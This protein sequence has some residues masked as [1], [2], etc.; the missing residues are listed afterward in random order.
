MKFVSFKNKENQERF[1]LLYKDTIV[2]LS[3]QSSHLENR[4]PSNILDFLNGGDEY[5][6]IVKGLVR[7]WDAKGGVNNAKT[8]G[9][10]LLSPIPHPPSCRDAYAFRQHV[11]S[12]RRNRGLEMIAE[13]DRFPVFYF[14]NHN[15]VN[16]EGNIVVEKDHLRS[17]DFELECAVVIGKRG[18]NIDV[19][20]ADEHIAGYMI[21]NDF[22]AREMQME[23]MK[24][25]LGPAKGK[26]F[27]TAFGPWLVTTDELN[28][29]KIESNTGTRYDLNMTARHNGMVVSEGNLK[30]MHFTFAEIIERCSYGVELIPGD[31]IGS[32]TVGAGCFLELNGTKK[33]EAA[34]KGEEFE[35]V[36]LKQG[37]EIELEITGLGT[38][39]NKIVLSDN[40]VG[41]KYR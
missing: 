25:N 14:A 21:M 30:D 33:R 27:A 6:G 8:D 13:F 39:K 26:D 7:D 37:D 4:I 36:W 15:A 11:E 29:Y 18:K 12:A 5:F 19:M 40:N 28:D 9:I 34:E 38:L 35:P 3:L 20:N 16:G 31:I 23:E 41:L 2:D 32:G 22:S 17:L 24:L 1:G 10:T